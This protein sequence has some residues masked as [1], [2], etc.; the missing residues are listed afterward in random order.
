MA[1]RSAG[2]MPSQLPI[3]PR[4]R[5]QPMQNPVSGSTTQIFTHGVSMAGSGIAFMVPD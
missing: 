2:D 5:P 3:S 1:W 4:V